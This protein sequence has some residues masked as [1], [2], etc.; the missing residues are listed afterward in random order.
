MLPTCS[1]SAELHELTTK[2]TNGIKASARKNDWNMKPPKLLGIAVLRL[3]CGGWLVGVLQR[4]EIVGQPKK[5]S[6]RCTPV[7]WMKSHV[8]SL[9]LMILP[10]GGSWAQA[11]PPS[12][13]SSL[14]VA[15]P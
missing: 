8:V 5:T 6:I 14:Q 15:A 4:M 2:P 12:D 9:I 13:G 10:P 7:D 3:G 1:G 11:F